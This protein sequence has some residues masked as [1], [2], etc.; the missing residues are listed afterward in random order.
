MVGAAAGPAAEYR[1]A[2]FN[3]RAG[4]AASL[5]PRAFPSSVIYRRS[6]SLEAISVVWQ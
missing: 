5:A 6:R 1:A 2:W 3:L 4:D